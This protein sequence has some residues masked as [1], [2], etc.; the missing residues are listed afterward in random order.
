MATFLEDLKSYLV[1]QKIENVFRDMLPDEPDNAVGLFLWSHSVPAIN[2]GAGARYV[3]VQVRDM[4]WDAAYLLCWK[5]AGLLDSGEN[6][7]QIHLTDKRWCIARPRAMPRK[8]SVD[9]RGRAT[10]YYEVAL[11]GDNIP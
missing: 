5:I 8:L 11:I 9:E 1:S 6:E 2:Y 7:A 10:Y 4:D 3:Q